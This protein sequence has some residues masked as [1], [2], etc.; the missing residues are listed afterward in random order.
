MPELLDII[1]QDDALGR[2]QRA[3]SG[4]RMP[5]ALLFAGPDGVGR[6]T[7]A[8]ALAKTLLCESPPARPNDGRLADLDAEAELRQACGQCRDCRMVAAESHP[9]F[10]LVYKELARYHEDAAVRERVMQGLGIDVIRRFLI[11]PCSR[12]STRGRGKVFVVLEADLMSTAAQNAL[13]KTLEEPPAR[14]TLI[15]ICGRP[16]QLLATTRS[17]CAL[18]RFGL[19]P[20]ELVTARLAA[21]GVAEVEAHF[22]AAFTGGSLGRAL[23]LAGRGMYKIKQEMVRRLGELGG[24]GDSGLGEHLAKTTD[25][26]ATE[27]VAAVKKADGATLSKALAGRRAVATML[28]LIASAFR[29]ALAVRTG[30]DLGMVHADQSEAV[31]GLA[32][33]FEPI[34]LA[35]IL[36]QLS[37]YERLLWRNVNPKIVWDNVVITC[38]SAAP[39]RL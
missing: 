13:L 19:L 30:A 2:I 11:G 28:E 20:R 3:M 38:A 34:E 27:A 10:H 32:Q 1:G 22:W 5:H 12:S 8:V 7:A 14:T 29:D 17:R 24:A 23:D 9:D 4:K 16:E 37:R 35:E 36:E 6:R 26:L 33:R 31:T 21:A 18:V 25:K 15:L 39:L